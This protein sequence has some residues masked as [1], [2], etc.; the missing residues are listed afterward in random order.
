MAKI[1]FCSVAMFAAFQKI[2]Y[3]WISKGSEQDNAAKWHSN[4]KYQHIFI[5]LYDI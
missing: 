1:I 2:Y 3:S 4:N 5:K